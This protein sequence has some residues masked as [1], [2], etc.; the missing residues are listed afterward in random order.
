[1]RHARL[2]PPPPPPLRVQEGSKV[3][4]MHVARQRGEWPDYDSP[5]LAL[6]PDAARGQYTHHLAAAAAEE[7]RAGGSAAAAPVVAHSSRSRSPWHLSFAGIDAEDGAAAQ[8]LG[9]GSAAAAAEQQRRAAAGA[10]LAAAQV[11]AQQLRM[12]RQQQAAWGQQQSTAASAAADEFDA[13]VFKEAAGECN[14]VLPL[15]ASSQCRA[16]AVHGLMWAALACL[17]SLPLNQ[18][19]LRSGHMPLACR[20]AQ[21]L[22]IHLLMPALLCRW[23]GGTLVCRPAAPGVRAAAAAAGGCP[24]GRSTPGAPAAR[25]A[26]APARCGL[27]KRRRQLVPAAWLWRCFCQDSCQDSRSLWPFRGM[28]PAPASPRPCRPS[29]APPC[30]ALQ[31]RGGWWRWRRTMRRTS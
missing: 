18:T 20:L 21:H 1:M 5:L 13:G 24:V 14:A 26:A 8:Q 19:Q 23:R 4:L 10:Q 3:Q 27:S 7:L 17:G 30:P 11:Q 6:P 2:M 22:P 15:A 12:L 29:P 28:P 16:A 9:A 31:M 25:P